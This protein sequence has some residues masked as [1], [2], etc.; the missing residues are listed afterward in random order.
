MKKV[1]LVDDDR[2]LL[3]DLGQVLRG[4]GYD[5]ATATTATEGLR[6]ALSFRPDV[7]VLDV[8]MET[9]TAGFEFAYQLRSERADSRY[10]EIRTTPIVLLTAI[11]QRTH[12]RFS[13]NEKASFLP[14]NVEMLTKPVQIEAL[15][16]RLQEAG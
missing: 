15:L 11:N 3:R 2:D 9:D 7:I 16:G 14:D 4:E 1:L 13:L 12:F 8:L 5:V 6:V 10:R